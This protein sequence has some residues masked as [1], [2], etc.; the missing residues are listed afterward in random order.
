MSAL[1]PQQEM[2]SALSDIH[3]VWHPDDLHPTS[4]RELKPRYINLISH[5]KLSASTL[6]TSSLPDPEVCVL[7]GSE[8]TPLLVFQESN[9]S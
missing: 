7:H 6:I 8:V 1:A 3:N 4:Q 9:H 2:C 5:P